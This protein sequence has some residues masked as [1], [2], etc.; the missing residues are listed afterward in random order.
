MEWSAIGWMEWGGLEWS[1]VECNG[2]EWKGMENGYGAWGD[3]DHTPLHKKKMGETIVASSPFFYEERDHCP[4][5]PSLLPSRRGMG[6]GHDH[7]LLR[8]AEYNSQKEGG[9]IAMASSSSPLGQWRLDGH[10]YTPLL[11][12]RRMGEP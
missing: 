2:V 1:G 7:T 8:R 11:P 10:D 3:H 12:G 6:G 4:W 9:K 5:L